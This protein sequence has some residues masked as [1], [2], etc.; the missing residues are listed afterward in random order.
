MN[1]LKE[2]TKEISINPIS[3]STNTFHY[4]FLITAKPYTASDSDIYNGRASV[5]SSVGEV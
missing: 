5:A 2:N 1:Q 4:N 3:L